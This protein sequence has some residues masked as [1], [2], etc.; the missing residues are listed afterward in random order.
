MSNLNRG[1]KGQQ[2]QN[3]L[4]YTTIWNGYLSIHPPLPPTVTRYIACFSGRRH[5]LMQPRHEGSG[6]FAF[7][8]LLPQGDGDDG[9]IQDVLDFNAPPPSQPVVWCDWQV[10]PLGTTLTISRPRNYRSAEWLKYLIEKFIAP[11]S[12]QVWRG[13]EPGDEGYLHVNRNVIRRHF[14]NQSVLGK[15]RN[16]PHKR[17]SFS[18]W[19]SSNERSAWVPPR[20]HVLT[21]IP[22][23]T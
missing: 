7:D 15:F 3:K 5:V 20:R 12:S 23:T 16:Q 17:V 4:G 14:F 2:N 13:E 8:S 6:E 11:C 9:N 21:P 19:V 18:F 1:E 22:P 10:D